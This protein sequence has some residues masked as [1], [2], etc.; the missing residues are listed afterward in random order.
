MNMKRY[1]SQTTN[2][3]YHSAWGIRFFFYGMRMLIRHPSL[4]G[5]SL[6]PI[7]FT[8]LLLTLFS[9]GSAWLVG[10]MITG[11]ADDQLRII[12]QAAI[13]ILVI[14]LAYFFYLPVARIVL[15]PFS[16]ALSRK[17][18]AINSEG[19]NYRSAV[20][21][22]R[23]MFEGLKLVTL[24]LTIAIAALAFGLI[25]PPVGAPVGIMVAIFLCGLDFLDVPLSARG[26]PLGKK[27]GVIWRNR[28]I[29]IGFGAAAYISLLIPLVNLILLPVGVIGAT[30][31]TDALESE[32]RIRNKLKS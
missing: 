2:P 26:L 18:H 13:F 22:G 17:A 28:S 15:A 5:L 11:V 29:A 21:W 25:F 23:A 19:S 3:F 8:L 6:I 32:E 27:V 9:I 4:L 30:L 20:G 14:F 10:G 31:L 16:E 24:Q 1:D 12:A 7:L